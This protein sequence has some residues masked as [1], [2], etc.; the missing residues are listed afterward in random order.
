MKIKPPFSRRNFKGQAWIL[1]NFEQSTRNGL[2]HLLHDLIDRRY[3]EN[4]IVVDKEL[5]R[6]SRLPPK[7]LDPTIAIDKKTALTSAYDLIENL[8]WDK[9]LDFIERLYNFLASPGYEWNGFSNEWE[10]TVDLEEVKSYIN[11]EINLLF[12]FFAL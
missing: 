5:R 10:A 3:I 8:K 6:I 1:K 12:H 11:N 2:L 4:W 9:L 7:E